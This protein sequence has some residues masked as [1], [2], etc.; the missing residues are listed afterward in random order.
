MSLYSHESRFAVVIAMSNPFKFGHR[1]RSFRFAFAG[2]RYM[3]K[4]Q[5]NAWIHALATLVV[6]AAAILFQVSRVDCCLLILACSVVWI[7]E[8]LNTALESLAD[9]VTQESHP[10]IG[11]AKDVAA[12]GVLL[13]AIGAVFVGIVVFGSHF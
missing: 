11:R 8:A 10:L 4:T 3:L 13:A 7:A 1:L 2:L 9:A 5:H 6:L 12:G